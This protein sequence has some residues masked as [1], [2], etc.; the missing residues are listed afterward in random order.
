MGV[1]FYSDGV[2][3]S[4]TELNR[5]LNVLICEEPPFFICPLFTSFFVF[6]KA[7]HNSHQKSPV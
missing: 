7:M 3:G 1:M 5:E 6:D 2:C 4:N